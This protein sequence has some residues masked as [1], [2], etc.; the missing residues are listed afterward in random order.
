MKTLSP[1]DQIAIAKSKAI[2]SAMGVLNSPDALSSAQDH[3]ENLSRLE[4]LSGITK[5]RDTIHGAAILLIVLATVGL[6]IGIRLESVALAA[7]VSASELVLTT[8]SMLVRTPAT[9]FNARVVVGGDAGVN[10][11]VRKLLAEP[12]AI[13]SVTEVQQ[14]SEVLRI[15]L[16][17]EAGCHL[18][19]VREG[20][21]AISLSSASTNGKSTPLDLVLR[22]S[23]SKAANLTI[24]GE[25]EQPLAMAAGLR[26]M[27]IEQRLNHGVLATEVLPSVLSGEF[28][29]GGQRIQLTPLDVLFVR[30]DQDKSKGYT[31]TALIDILATAVS[32]RVSTNVNELKVGTVHNQ[33]NFMPN[34]LESLSRDSPLG[35]AYSSVLAVFAFLWGLR[36]VLVA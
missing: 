12:K 28:N 31:S 21:L 32:V 14:T 9:Y 23:N 3:L 22:G 2:D 30:T 19:V 11:E 15:V 10:D 35:T 13:L 33:K 1:G 36:K 7:S 5:R 4:A 18:L 26:D 27:T 34:V 17:Q 6:T 16:R 24:C 8:S 20:S 29:V 25:V